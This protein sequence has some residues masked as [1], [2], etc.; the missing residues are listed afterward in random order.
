MASK[1][2]PP[3]KAEDRK[4]DR[5]IAR[6]PDT[7]EATREDFARSKLAKEVLPAD[8]YQAVRRRG[9]RGPQKRPKKVPISIRIDRDVL[10][11]Y[12]ATGRGYQARMNQALREG[13]K[14]L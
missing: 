13:A 8:L 12:C 4:I 1:L 14:F 3:S 6:D 9:Q 11:A 10:A 2:L 7:F 5:G